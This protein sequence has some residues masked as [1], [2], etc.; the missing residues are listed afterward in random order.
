MQTCS[1]PFPLAVNSS[2]H[3]HYHRFLLGADPTVLAPFPRPYC[4]GAMAAEMPGLTANLS[5]P[6]WRKLYH[7]GFPWVEGFG[8]GHY[9]LGNV[10]A[11]RPLPLEYARPQR[12]FGAFD[13]VQVADP[14]VSALALVAGDRRVIERFI[15]LADRFCARLETGVGAREPGSAGSRTT[16]R[17]ACGQFAE[18]NNR[19]LMPFLHVHSRVLNFTS[20]GENPSRLACLDSAALERAGRR[21]RS[22]WIA[23]QADVLSELGYRVAPGSEASP[24]LQVEGVTARLTAAMQAPRIAV[25]RLLERMIVGNLPPSADRLGSLLPPAVIAA[26]AEEIE[27]ALARSVSSFKPA[28]I[29]VPAEGPWRAAVREHLGG[30]VPGSLSALD[31]A[32]ARARAAPYESAVFTAPC[33]D[34]AHRHAPSIDES[35]AQ[36]QM[37]SDP[38]LGADLRQA[39]PP[40]APPWLVRE[41][42]SVLGEVNARVVRVGPEDPLVALGSLLATIDQLAEGASPEQLRQSSSLVAVEMDRARMGPAGGA[43]PGPETPS[44]G[45][46][47]L[48]PL[49]HLFEDAAV[50]RSA[51]PAHEMGGRSL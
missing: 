45:R 5:L 30:L 17:M 14:S 8:P 46:G 35:E 38:E 48:V 2:H 20:F 28:K 4:T 16:G 22:G 19:W 34:P 25:L 31:A 50:F 40:P 6:R 37:P 7:G 36:L 47:R 13:F 12:R 41:F 44:W 29:G 18:P 51:V 39:R 9:D 23:Q 15:A 10:P 26:M 11:H 32:A 3:S 33:L 1:C 27:S 21:A 43:R 49:E 42:E 24:G